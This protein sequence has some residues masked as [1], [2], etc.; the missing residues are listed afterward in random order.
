MLTKTTLQEKLTDLRIRNGYTNTQDLADAIGIPK[1]TLNNCENDDKDIDIGYKTLTKLA[2]FY[3]VSLDYLVGIS[4]I[5]EHLN[6]DIM[7]IGLTDEIIDVLKDK[8]INTRLLCEMILHPEFNHLL[9]DIEIYIDG[10]I[11]NQIDTTNVILNRT[12]T[13][14]QKQSNADDDYF[15]H[16]FERA[17][18]QEDRYFNSIIHED[19]DTIVQDLRLN[20]KQLKKDKQVANDDNLGINT[21]IEMIEKLRDFDGTL[22][23]NKLKIF[24]LLFDINVNRLNKQEI[25]LLRKILSQGNSSWKKK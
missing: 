7:D 10:I 19:I 25:T 13:M 1:T 20:H 6:A 17:K 18:I 15:M 22:S 24:E 5:Q 21:F 23:E 4:D 14:I 2:E 12:K 3:N 9:M 11:T 8:K 16:C